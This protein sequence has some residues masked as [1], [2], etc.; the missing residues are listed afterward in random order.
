MTL[1]GTLLRSRGWRQNLVAGL[2]GLLIGSIFACVLILWNGP[3]ST[4]IMREERALE[5]TARSN[6]HL[7]L[8]MNLDR[9]HDCPSETSRWLWTWVEH[10]GQQIKQFYPLINTTTTLSELGRSQEFILSI[11]IPPGVWPG[12]WHYWSKTVEHCPFS[13]NSVR[14]SGNIPIQIVDG[15]P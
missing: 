14:E 9:V 3:P 15:A 12:E 10:D 5:E 6:G 1:I 4:V 11:P 8:Y 13:R 7:D 2:A